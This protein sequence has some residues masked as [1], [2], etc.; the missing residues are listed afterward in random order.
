M[1]KH[2]YIPFHLLKEDTPFIAVDCQHPSA[3]ELSHWRGAKLS[4]QLEADTSTAIVLKALEQK[5]TE[6]NDYQ[7]ASVNHF[8][9]DGFLGLWCLLNREKALRQKEVIREMAEVGDF[10][11]CNPESPN[12]TYILKLVSWINSVE[13]NRYYPPF[14]AMY[15]AEKEVVSCAEKFEYFLTAFAY[16][17][18]HLATYKMEWEGEYRKVML[19]QESYR[20]NANTEYFEDIRLFVV[21]TPEPLH[22]YALF[23]ESKNADMVLSIYDN[24]RYELEYKYSTWVNAFLRNSFP[25][26]DLSL[27]AE[28]LNKIEKSGKKWETQSIFDTGPILSLESNK[29]NKAERYNS[30]F[31]RTIPPSSI[32]EDKLIDEVVAFYQSAYKKVE[33]KNSWS[34]EEITQI[35]KQIAQ[36]LK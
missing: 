21:R 4:K 14:G 25:R 29:N 35:N 22:Y 17:K 13:N 1:I 10:R 31:G 18:E 6:L 27:L 24:N 12:F 2:K 7:F 5:Q 11:E 26:I 36:S 20:K 15:S 34:W 30:P 8:D 28:R 32:P 19:D 16:V 33:R 9:V 23:S 3:F